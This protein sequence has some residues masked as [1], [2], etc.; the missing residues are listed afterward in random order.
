MVLTDLSFVR[1]HIG[2]HDMLAD[3]NP[4]RDRWADLTKSDDDNYISHRYSVAG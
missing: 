3:A 2:Q 1:A 4:A